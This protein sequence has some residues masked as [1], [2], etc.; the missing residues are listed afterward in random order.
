MIQ[1]CSIG[2]WSSA[3]LY[4]NSKKNANCEAG[5][6][7]LINRDGN[8]N[9]EIGNKATM[10]AIVTINQTKITTLKKW[11]L[12]IHRTTSKR[13]NGSKTLEKRG[14]NISLSVEK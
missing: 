2:D 12:S 5:T 9:S 4:I 8:R 6:A 1:N 3:P 14:K 11:R 13:I 7:K 10:R